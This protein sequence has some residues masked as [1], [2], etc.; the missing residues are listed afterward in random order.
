MRGLDLFSL[1]IVTPLL[2]YV[3]YNRSFTIVQMYAMYDDNEIGAL[4]CDEIEGHVETDSDLLMQY[5]TEF[6]KQK[7]ED[8]SII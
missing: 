7:N 8:V 5:A 3:F 4:D 1:K 2:L 6:E